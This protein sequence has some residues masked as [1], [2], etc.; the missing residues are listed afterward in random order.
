MNKTVWLYNGAITLKTFEK[1]LWVYE[2]IKKSYL[3]VGV[4]MYNRN[5]TD[6]YEEKFKPKLVGYQP[7]GANTVPELSRLLAKMYKH[8]IL[9]RHTTEI[10]GVTGLGFRNWI[11]SYTIR[12]HQYADYF[13]REARKE[14]FK[15]IEA[16]NE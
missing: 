7:Y 11:Y 3:N 14:Y 15:K 6:D 12:G 4:N 1:F 16:N 2:Y 13:Y 10:D 9:F 5:F 8:K